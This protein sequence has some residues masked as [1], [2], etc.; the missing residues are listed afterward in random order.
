MTF[1]KETL[2]SSNRWM[3][4][5]HKS[6]RLQPTKRQTPTAAVTPGPVDAPNTATSISRIPPSAAR[7]RLSD[8]RFELILYSAG[9]RG[10]ISAVSDGGHPERS[11]SDLSIP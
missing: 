1:Q 7:C 4:V 5:L 2:G 8:H 6:W 11:L 3:N 10:F 9:R